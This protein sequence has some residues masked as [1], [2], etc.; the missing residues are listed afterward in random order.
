VLTQT[1]LQRL[2]ITM[3]KSNAKFRHDMQIRSRRRNVPTEND[4]KRYDMI[5]LLTAVG[6]TSA[7]CAIEHLLWEERV[8][9]LTDIDL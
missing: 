1:A 8:R 7:L 5:Y 6:L 3:Y 9:I 4:M 2:Q